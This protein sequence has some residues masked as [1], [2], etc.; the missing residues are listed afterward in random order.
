MWKTL[1]NENPNDEHTMHKLKP[2]TTRT[3][4]GFINF[5]NFMIF[6]LC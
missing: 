5:K 3:Q 1:K 6:K 2:K 4:Y